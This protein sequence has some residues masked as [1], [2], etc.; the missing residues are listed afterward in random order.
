MQPAFVELFA[1]T[2]DA[3]NEISPQAAFSRNGSAGTG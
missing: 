3:R 2:P 1:A